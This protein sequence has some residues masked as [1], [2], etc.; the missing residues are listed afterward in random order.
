MR[1]SPTDPISQ[2][3]KLVDAVNHLSD[4]LVST[5][6]TTDVQQALQRFKERT[7]WKTKQFEF[8]LRTELRRLAAETDL[9][10]NATNMD[11]QTGFETILESYQQALASHLTAHTRAM[12]NRQLREMRIAY[13]E[14][15]AL[16]KAA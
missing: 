12:V 15:A 3:I 7:H 16:C 11:L 13:E 2:M 9:A 14:F 1:E 10:A 8:E 5:T 6:A 4:L